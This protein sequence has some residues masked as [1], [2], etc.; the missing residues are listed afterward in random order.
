MDVYDNA[1]MRRVLGLPPLVFWYVSHDTHGAC[2][3][4]RLEETPL[5]EICREDFCQLDPFIA[6][7][8]WERFYP[9]KPLRR[10]KKWRGHLT[11]PETKKNGRGLFR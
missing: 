11:E 2:H 4:L 8:T 1:L 3:L 5:E 7:A 9:D 6:L 10:P